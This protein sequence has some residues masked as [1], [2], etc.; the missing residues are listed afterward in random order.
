MGG[1]FRG[2]CLDW[3]TVRCPMVLVVLAIMACLCQAK[4]QLVP[5]SVYVSLDEIEHIRPV[6][7]ILLEA[8]RNSLLDGKSIRIWTDSRRVVDLLS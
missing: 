2:L 3:F 8:D 4:P 6:F 1:M 5:G 7:V